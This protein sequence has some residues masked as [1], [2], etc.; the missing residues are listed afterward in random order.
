[1][2]RPSKLTALEA[3]AME[4]LRVR[5]GLIVAAHARGKLR[6]LQRLRDKGLAV[7]RNGWYR[8]Q[9]APA[10]CEMVHVPPSWHP[11][12]GRRRDEVHT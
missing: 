7:Y 4:L 6:P 2:A 3:A 5:P 8:T 10:S 11:L 9:D 1:M 12:P